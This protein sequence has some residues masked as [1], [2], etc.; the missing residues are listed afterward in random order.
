MVTNTKPSLMTTL[1]FCMGQGKSHYS[2]AA[3]NTILNLLNKFHQIH[4][5]RRWLFQ[6]LKDFTDDGLIKRTTRYRHYGDGQIVQIPSM[7]VFRLKGIVQLSRMG[8][9]GAKEIY[10]KM[11]THINGPDKRAPHQ[12]DLDDGSWKPANPEE[13][14]RMTGLLGIVTKNIS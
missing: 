13:R 5:K 12:D 9:K 10:R 2:T 14:K 6:C 4:V 8:I 3:V 1:F 7:I 11:V